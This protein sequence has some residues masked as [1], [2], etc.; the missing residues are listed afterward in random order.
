MCPAMQQMMIFLAG[1]N[2]LIAVAAGAFGAHGLRAKL[3]HEALVVFETAARYHMYHALALAAL[4]GLAGNASSRLFHASA[5]SFQCGIILFCGSLYAM[6]LSR[7]E[8]KWLGPITPIGGL[9][10]LIG[11]L[12]FAL[13]GVSRAAN[14][15]PPA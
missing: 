4:A 8:W 9:F 6:A 12:C 11:W 3:T 5:V 10:F 2:G 14:A 15:I 13:A 1:V 7:M